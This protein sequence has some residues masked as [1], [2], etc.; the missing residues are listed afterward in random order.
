MKIH[1]YQAKK[2]LSDF[3]VSIQEGIVASNAAEAEAAFT[4]LGAPLA[5]V[6][7]QVHAGGRGKGG[8]VKLV[9]SAAEAKE[10]AGVMLGNRLITHQTGPQGVPVNKVLVCPGV[11]IAKEFYAGMVIDRV[12]GLVLMASAEGGVEI[13]EVAQKSPEKILKEIVDIRYGLQVFQAKRLAIALGFQE[14]EL[15]TV[16]KIFQGMTAAFIAHDCSLV[17]INPLVRTKD[18]KIIALDAKV[19]FDDNADF[20]HPIYEELR[21]NSET[22]AAEIQAAK[23]KLSFVKLDGNIGCM[24]NGAGLAMAT[25]DIIKRSG[26][27]PANFLD[28]GGGVQKDQVV[29]AFKIIVADP[30]V[31]AILVNIFGGIAKCDTIAEGIVNAAKELGLK[32]PLVVRLEGTNMEKGIEILNKSGLKIVSAKGMQ[33]AAEKAVA[34]AKASKK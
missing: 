3:G 6:K 34:A 11:D 17:E 33:D 27:E 28:V 20:R 1:E 24:V 23:S 18:G 4:K 12:L 5:V 10:K 8:G 9:R 13:E 25:M 21:D 19:L 7:A 29:E 32:C 22:N 14:N 2:I 31:Q 15:E 16:C 26:G 30:H